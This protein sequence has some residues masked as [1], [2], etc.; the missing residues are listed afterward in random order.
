MSEK[1]K[2]TVVGSGYVGMSRG[3]LLAQHFID[4]WMLDSK[5]SWLSARAP[6]GGVVISSAAISQLEQFLNGVPCDA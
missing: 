3:V 6:R 5:I 4:Q 2:V 1:V